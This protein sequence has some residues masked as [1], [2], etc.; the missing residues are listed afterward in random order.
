[1]IQVIKKI[2]DRDLFILIS[3]VGL[4]LYRTFGHALWLVVSNRGLP[5]SPD[6][7][8]YIN[9]AYALIENFSIHLNVDE[10]LYVG[11][12][13]LL[14]LLLF[15]FR[16]AVMVIYIQALTASLAII[17]VYKISQDL[18]NQRTAVFA[19][20]GYLCLWDVT[21][22]SLYVLSDS[23]F[24][25]LLLLCVYFLIKAMEP[26]AR[27]YKALFAAS[28]L[29]MCFFRPAGIV[30]MGVMLVYAVSR[31]ERKRIT[32]ILV[33]FRAAIGWSLV[34][35][36]TVLGVF[37][38]QHVF[39]ILIYSLQYNAK[40]IMYNI[41]AKGWIYDISTAYNYVYRPDYTIDIHDSLVL[42]FI[43]NNWEAVSVLYVRRAVAFLGT[44]AWETNVR[45]LGDALY[46]SFRLLPLGL[47]V[48]GTVAAVRNGKFGKSSILW[49]IIFAVFVFCLLL[50]IDA[51]YR[52][53][54]PAMPLIAIVVAYGADRMISG[55]RL[56][57]KNC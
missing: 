41:Y 49:L 10:V 48:V 5:Q 23:F 51:M 21:L 55:G 16:D 2:K 28:S 12:N 15:L 1:V 40:L 53:R 39:D 19:A 26:G 45:T 32:V 6:G 20:I 8:W 54:F 25:S 11:Y 29:Y 56:L 3:F 57:A 18:F 31:L 50:F 14:T 7:Q 33:E 42:S 47:F 9:Y 46:Y 27:T 44:W 22:W 30:V 43:I 37:Y 13:L 35:L 17:L 24:S 36:V 34:S 38:S 4:S 52:Y